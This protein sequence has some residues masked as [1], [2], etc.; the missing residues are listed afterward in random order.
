M[1]VVPLGDLTDLRS[2]ELEIY[3]YTVSFLGP[4]EEGHPYGTLGLTF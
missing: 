4:L 3:P 2:F 1:D